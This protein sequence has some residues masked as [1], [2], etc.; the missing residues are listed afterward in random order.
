MPLS[1][2]G[3]QLSIGKLII[4]HLVFPAPLSVKH[5]FVKLFGIVF[6][7]KKSAGFPWISNVLPRKTLATECSCTNTQ[8]GRRF[9]YK[10]LEIL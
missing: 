8:V 10:Y 9:P 2:G 3:L 7:K 4:G 1:F 6:D 5:F